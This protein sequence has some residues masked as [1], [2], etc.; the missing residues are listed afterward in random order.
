VSAASF[1]SLATGE[2]I[3]SLARDAPIVYRPFWGS[4]EE[5]RFAR[6]ETSLFSVIYSTDTLLGRAQLQM[7]ALIAKLF[8]LFRAEF[9]FSFVL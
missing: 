6:F 8:Q 4:K 9:V 2:I 7:G 5:R 3:R 1:S